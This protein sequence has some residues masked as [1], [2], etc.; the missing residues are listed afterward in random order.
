MFYLKEYNESQSIVI[1][2]ASSI[3][4]YPPREPKFYFI[5]GPP[6]IYFILYEIYLKS[7]IFRNWKITY[8]CRYNPNN[9]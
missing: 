3:L 6:G 8:N 4:N 1:A 2:E 5:Q 7:S 9:V